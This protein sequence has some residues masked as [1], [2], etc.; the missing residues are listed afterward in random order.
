MSSNVGFATVL[1][2]RARSQTIESFAMMRSWQPTLVSNGEAERLPAVRV[3][4]NY[5]DMMGVRPALGR[6]FTADDDRPG[7][8]RVLLLSDGLWR[9]RFGTDPSVVGRSVVMND[10]EYRI[11]GVMP[12]SFEPLDAQRYYKA[13]AEIWAPIG[14]DLNGDSSCRG[15]RHLRGFGRLKRGVT[16][17]DETVEMNTI[18]EQMR[19]EHPDDYD[20]G[21]IAVVPLRDALTGS[22]RTALFVLLAAV[23]FVLLIACANVANLLLARSV[24]RQRE[25]ALR[26]VLGAGR[27]RIIRQLLTES[28]ML[29]AGGAKAVWGSAN[30]IG[31][32][33][34]LGGHTR[35]PWRTIIGVVADV[36]HD[37]LTEPPAPAMYTPQTQITDSYLTA[38][39]KSSTRDAAALAPL[40]RAVLRELD[41]TVPVY[42]VA[43]VSSLIEKA[44]AHRM[45]VMRL[46]AGFAFVAVLLAAIGLYGVVSH[47]VAQRTREVGVRVALGAQRR[48][49]L[50]LVLSSGLSLVALGVAGGLAAAFAST[51]YL[52]TLMFGVS[53]VDPPTFAA[54]TG[55]LTFVAL[56]AH[57]VPIRRALRIDPAT[58]LRAE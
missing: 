15:C 26:A 3:S 49:V 21:T 55:V 27:A 4:W 52:G 13:D 36:D 1:D 23:G 57:W 9:R 24:T 19:R 29:S 58:A 28:V 53:A 8:S 20:S 17:A 48:D 38:V 34:R 56:L 43:T 51:R 33:V 44:A 46:L 14:Y 18:R 2:W 12:A 37:D 50:R 35:G 42:D 16:V 25:L 47:G 30:P 10:R 45:F 31:S 11:V 39:V 41:P 22:V 6:S 5:F 54:A 32:Q 40:A 7:H